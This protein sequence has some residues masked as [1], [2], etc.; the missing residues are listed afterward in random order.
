MNNDTDVLEFD[1]PDYEEPY[2]PFPDVKIALFDKEDSYSRNR[3]I[4]DK[5][6]ADKLEKEKLRIKKLRKAVRKKR[7]RASRSKKHPLRRIL[8]IIALFFAVETSVLFVSLGGVEALTEYIE[9]IQNGTAVL[10]Q[11][12]VS[13][14]SYVPAKPF[15]QDD[16]GEYDTIYTTDEMSFM[17]MPNA[18][19]DVITV[20][21]WARNLTE[22]KCWIMCDNFYLTDGEQTVRDYNIISYTH[23]T[24]RY[25]IYDEKYYKNT[26]PI[27][28]GFNRTGRSAFYLEFSLTQFE[29]KGQIISIGY[30]SQHYLGV[31]IENTPDDFEVPFLIYD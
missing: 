17:F 21:V 24:A 20:G 31:L 23:E 6:Y 16:A 19:N 4:A 27:A 26:D 8:S 11:T 25:K 1:F 13:E 29:E 28:F 2:P 15:E 9:S 18:S 30:D 7:K 5:L 22:E 3:D 14:K 12:A 10:P